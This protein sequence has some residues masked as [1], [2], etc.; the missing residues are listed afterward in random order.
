M[1]ASLGAEGPFVTSLKPE[2]SALFNG[3]A[4]KTFWIQLSLIFTVN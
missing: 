1:G 3:T 2:K 4:L